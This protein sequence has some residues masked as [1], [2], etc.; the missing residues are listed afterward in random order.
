MNKKKY[1]QFM[2]FISMILLAILIPV[3]CTHVKIE[4]TPTSIASEMPVVSQTTAQTAQPSATPDLS[5][6]G[7][8]I[9]LIG[10]DYAPERD[11]WSGKHMYHADIMMVLHIDSE[12]N[13]VSIISL[14]KDTYSE[15]P[16]VTGIYKLN[17]SL[18]CGGDWPSQSACEKVCEAASWTV[19]G[20]PIKYYYAV[21][22]TAAKDIVTEIGGIDFDLDVSF[23]INQR[24]YNKG[25]QHMDGQAVLDYLR[26]KDKHIENYDS[27]MGDQAQRQQKMMLA[28]LQNLKDSGQISQLP[29]I[30]NDFK[31]NHL[32]TNTS[33]AQTAALAACLS[34]IKSEDIVFNTMSG[35][36]VALGNVTYT[37]TYGDNRRQV[38]QDVYGI[39]ITD[40]AAAEEAGISV[41]SYTD[42]SYAS[43]MQ[44]WE[45]MEIYVVTNQVKGVLDNIKAKLDADAHSKYLADGE[46]WELYNKCESEYEQ[47]ANWDTSKTSS[48]DFSAYNDFLD[49][50][51]EDVE[52]LC[53][54]FSIT[55]ERN[56]W[57]VIYNP[58]FGEFNQPYVQNQIAVDPR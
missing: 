46:E 38:I 39:D 30:I 50:L 42:Y 47:L 33:L 20:L 54:M 45:K 16:G 7:E 43:A 4:A 26:V 37:F 9:M 6:I 49:G 27:S 1:S 2:I 34:S 17:A 19:G 55:I 36:T 25:S 52:S 23:T 57:D 32:V 24:S 21:D 35:A 8:N 22:I 29:A 10:V 53:G 31:S 13:K 48:S 44:L 3:G 56:Y 18:N 14:P 11:T 51:E 40:Q 5:V 58:Y 28:I 12:T 41:P 15:I